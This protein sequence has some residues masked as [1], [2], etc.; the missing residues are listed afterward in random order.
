VT[1]SVTAPVSLASGSTTTVTASVFTSDGRQLSGQAITWASSNAPVARVTDGTITGALVGTAGITASV[2]SVSSTPLNVTVTPGAPAQLTVRTQPAGARV[3]LP[4]ATQPAIDIKDAAGNLVSNATLAIAAAIGSGGGTLAGA[5]TATAANGTAA[6]TGLSITG[7]IGPRTLTFTATGV[8]PVTS[9]SIN[10]TAGDPTAAAVVQQ[11]IGGAIGAAM[12]VP[13][14]IELRDVAGNVATGATSPVVASVVGGTAAIAAGGSVL[15]VNGRATFS[16][17]TLLGPIGT[18]TLS[19][20]T[21]GI[22]PLNAQPISLAT[23]VYGT[24]LQKILLVNAGQSVAPVVSAAQLPQ[25]VSSAPSRVSVD[26]LGR[27]QGRAE[28]QSW[29]SASIP[30]GADS[31]LVIVP[32]TADGPVIAASLPGFTLR[33]GATDIDLIIIPRGMPIGSFT[34]FVSLNTQDFTAQFSPF[35]L[36]IPGAQVTAIQLE[37]GLMRFS[38]VATTPITQ[39]TA[40]GRVTLLNGPPGTRLTL[41]VNALDA[42]APDGTDLFPFITSTYF[43]LTFR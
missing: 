7:T 10:L 2:G 42:N 28:G 16:T 5:T 26:N 17:L 14:I 31:I 29:V 27:M 39:T 36:T 11:P 30:A 23:I 25:F 40:F 37:G 22:P 34:A 15:P 20:S 8:T 41:A 19:F 43:P 6:F 33:G 13:P 21:A 4:F 35:T 1:L 24:A 32:R 38:V 3:A 9:G 18:Y 12:V